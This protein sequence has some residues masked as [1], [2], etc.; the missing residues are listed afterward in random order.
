MPSYYQVVQRN[1]EFHVV[2][3]D[4]NTVSVHETK[5]EAKAHRSEHD[6]H[7][8]LKPKSKPVTQVVGVD[9]IGSGESV[10]GS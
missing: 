4:G 7:E 10:H 9:G 1:G 5:A 3:S 8:N 6:A 2:D